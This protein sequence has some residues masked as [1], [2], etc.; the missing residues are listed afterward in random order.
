MLEILFQD[1]YVHLHN[2]D[3]SLRFLYKDSWQFEDYFFADFEQLDQKFLLQLNFF[4]HYP[5]PKLYS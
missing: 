3:L 5:L 1:C 4:F 2:W